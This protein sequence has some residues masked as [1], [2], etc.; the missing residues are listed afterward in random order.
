MDLA[1]IFK[2]KKQIII[3]EGDEVK[4]LADGKKGR[5]ESNRIRVECNVRLDKSMGMMLAGLMEVTSR[6]R[7]MYNLQHN[8][9][10]GLAIRFANIILS[11]ADMI[12]DEM[13]AAA[14][15]IMELEKEDNEI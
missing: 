4:V 12:N 7:A 9:P 11:H 5:V 3:T 10:D 1:Q 8:P 6:F 13:T 2:K 14:K 15:Q